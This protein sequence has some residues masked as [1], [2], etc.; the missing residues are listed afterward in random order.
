MQGG[1]HKNEIELNLCNIFSI[2]ITNESYFLMTLNCVKLGRAVT[3]MKYFAT[4]SVVSLILLQKTLIW[5]KV[6]FLTSNLLNFAELLENEL[7]KSTSIKPPDVHGPQAFAFSVIT[8]NY[9]HR[10]PRFKTQRRS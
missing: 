10:K 8:V 1:L 2:L 3:F 6:T 7:M 4:A 9:E 5:N